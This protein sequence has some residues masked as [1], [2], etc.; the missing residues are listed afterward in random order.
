MSL[1]MEVYGVKGVEKRLDLLEK[2]VAK[3][4]VSQAVQKVAKSILKTKMKNNA[5]SMVGGEMGKALAKSISTYVAKKRNNGDF[6]V[7]ARTKPKKGQEHFIYM[8]KSQ[9]RS[10]VPHA[11]EFGHGNT[12]PIPFMRKAWI[13][14]MRTAQKALGK[15]IVSN[16]VKQA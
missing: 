2:K 5:T 13:E 10:Y 15:Q 1:K 4:V 3:K 8:S 14:S 12:K 9:K 11:I 6:M 16:I 7:I